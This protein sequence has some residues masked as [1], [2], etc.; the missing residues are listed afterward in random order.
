MEIQYITF[1][2][3]IS[4]KSGS[5]N[6]SSELEVMLKCA[7][8]ASG[9]RVQWVVVGDQRIVSFHL[10]AFDLPDLYAYRRRSQQ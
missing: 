8:S 3:S 5:E 7:I 2:V 10:P 4:N 6:Q 9:L 1:A